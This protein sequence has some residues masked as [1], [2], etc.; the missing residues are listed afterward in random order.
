MK[1]LKKL[2]YSL[3]D[4]TYKLKSYKVKFA[5]ISN[6][7]DEVGYLEKHI[8][9]SEYDIKIQAD[10]FEIYYMFKKVIEK[11]YGEKHT[12]ECKDMLRDTVTQRIETNKESAFY[13]NKNI[14]KVSWEI[15]TIDYSPLSF[16]EWE[17]CQQK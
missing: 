17:K 8:D 11:L 6:N 3:V 2:K 13:L 14:V 7:G 4:K 15:D 1:L 16:E 10:A 9:M 12:Q 5:Y